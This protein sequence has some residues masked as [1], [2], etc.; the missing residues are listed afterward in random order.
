ML[1]LLVLLCLEQTL[2]FQVTITFIKTYDYDDY[3][4]G[5]STDTLTLTVGDAAGNSSTE[6]VTINISS[7]NQNPSIS[8]LSAD[9]T[10]IDKNS[11][12]TQ[13][14]YTAVVT[15]NVGINSISLTGATQD[16][17]SVHHTFQRIWLCWL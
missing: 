16:S 14:V 11:A 13:T 3:S 9:D 4:F 17:V 8:S 7:D 10:S 2:I 1:E 6:S 5:S 15:D 12:Q